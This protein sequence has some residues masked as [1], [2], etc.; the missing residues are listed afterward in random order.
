[1]N[2]IYFLQHT[3][4]IPAGTFNTQP[5][6]AAASS[7]W[8]KRRHHESDEEDWDEDREFPEDGWHDTLSDD[9]RYGGDGFYG[10]DERNDE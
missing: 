8:R 1:M 7:N 3:P 6:L 10:G 5:S 4:S 9:W 2:S